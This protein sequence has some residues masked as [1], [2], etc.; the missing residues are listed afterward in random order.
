MKYFICPED[1]DCIP[2]AEAENVTEAKEKICTPCIEVALEDFK[3]D[4][5]TEADPSK[6]PTIKEASRILLI[7][8]GAA[9]YRRRAETEERINN[10]RTCIP[11]EN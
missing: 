6:I 11:A 4:G 3:C 1:P 8:I 10:D 2:Y 9:F 5:P 7:N